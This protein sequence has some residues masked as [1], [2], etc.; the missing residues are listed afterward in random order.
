LHRGEEAK[1]VGYCIADRLSDAYDGIEGN[2]I[3]PSRCQ[4]VIDYMKIIPVKGVD[5]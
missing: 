3:G 2:R 1:V 5:G 4:M